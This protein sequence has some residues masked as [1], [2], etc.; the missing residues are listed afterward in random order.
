MKEKCKEAFFLF[1][2]RTSLFTGKYDNICL[3]NDCF[4][5]VFEAFIESA[6]WISFWNSFWI[7]FWINFGR[8][9]FSNF[10]IYCSLICCVSSFLMLFDVFWRFLM[11]FDDSRAN[12]YKPSSKTPRNWPLFY[13]VVVDR[14][15]QTAWLNCSKYSIIGWNRRIGGCRF[16]RGRI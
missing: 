7:S 13:L 9:R 5:H 12:W 14:V 16:C 6:F 1:D 2:V 15:P 10:K 11:I 8:F 3:L 4:E